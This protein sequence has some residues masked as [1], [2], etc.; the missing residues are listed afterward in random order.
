MA[1]LTTVAYLVK[2]AGKTSKL[3]EGHEYDDVQKDTK[4]SEFLKLFH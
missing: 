1:A 2:A 4:F 3:F